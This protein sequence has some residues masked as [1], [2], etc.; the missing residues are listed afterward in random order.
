MPEISAGDYENDLE[1]NG[2]MAVNLLRKE[3]KKFVKEL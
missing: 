1:K 2:F 3:P